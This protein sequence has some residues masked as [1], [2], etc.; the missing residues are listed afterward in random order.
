MCGIVV[1]E[2]YINSN[3]VPE[4]V[5]AFPPETPQAPQLSTF[6]MAA[7]RCEIDRSYACEAMFLASAAPGASY[8]YQFN[9]RTPRTG[10][11]NHG[12]EIKYVFGH[13]NGTAQQDDVANLTM[14]Y[15]DSFAR[16]GDPNAPGLAHW[17]QWDQAALFNSSASSVLLAISTQAA[18]V[19]D[20][21]LEGCSFF[22]TNWDYLKVCLP[23]NPDTLQGG[24]GE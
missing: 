12:D 3:N 10:M 16:A 20:P 14:A 24:W 7:Q 22:D 8:V 18:L 4:L 5:H 17:P 23:Q 13:A 1:Y 2:C 6:F 19:F 21:N 9:E 11:A 15:W